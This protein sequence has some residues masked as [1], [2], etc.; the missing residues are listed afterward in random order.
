MDLLQRGCA[1][2]LTVTLKGKYVGPIGPELKGGCWR[3]AQ[4]HSTFW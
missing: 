4:K 3:G 2:K 1:V